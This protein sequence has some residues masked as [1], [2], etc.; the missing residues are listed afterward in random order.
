[1]DSLEEQTRVR[2]SANTRNWGNAER[3]ARDIERA[4]DL[5]ARRKSSV[6]LNGAAHAFISDQVA[7]K[8]AGPSIAKSNALLERQFLSWCQGRNLQ[9][10][11]EIK[12]SD[13]REF[14][15]TWINTAVTALRKHELLRSFFWF[16]ISNGWMQK[17]P[18]D[19][20]KK[21][22]VPEV[23]PTDYFERE[24][25]NQIV[26]ATSAYDY[27]GGNDCQHRPARLRALVLL[28]RWS[29][30][31]IKDAVTLE[32]MRLNDS[33]VVYLRRA[34]TGVPVA[35]PLPPGV[36]SLLRKLPCQ[37][38]NY[39]FWSGNGDAKSAVKPYQRSFWKLFRLANITK[40][41]GTR[42]R[43]HSHMFRDTFAVELLL[44][45]VPID[46]V[47]VLLGHR[48]VKMT[49]KHYLPWAK[50]RQDQLITSVQRAW[51][52]EVVDG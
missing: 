47:S 31:A 42:K 45:G 14:R 15:S 7:R 36:V 51:F 39:F 1:M 29:G 10:L 38:T 27:G 17:N 28:M 5:S 44:S 11:D 37:N 34:K 3:K 16:C 40:P 19:G 20:L 35:V 26:N 43:C 21:P 13:M 48:S 30:L 33:G 9:Y 12:A 49:E 46:Q 50:A 25:F 18:M 23:A 41:D 32:R 6:T 52:P 4:A 2:F 22:K 8:L 24:E